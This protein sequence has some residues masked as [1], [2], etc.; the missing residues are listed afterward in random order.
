MEVEM[1]IVVGNEKGGVGKSTIACNLAVVM[2]IEGKD[3]CIVDVDKQQSTSTFFSVRDKDLPSVNCV[4]AR[5]DVFDVLS[6]LD[7][8][9]DEIIVD[10]GGHDSQELRTAM[11]AANLLLVPIKAS[12]IDLWSAED[13]DIGMEKLIAQCKQ[14]NRKLIVKTVLSIIPTCVFG[15]E[16]GDAAAVIKELPY[17]GFLVNTQLK[18]RKVYRESFTKGKGV[19]EMPNKK[20]AD[21]FHSLYKE[22]TYDKICA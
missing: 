16:A 21:E 14:F 17:M 12:Q 11:L 19:V 4:Q 3:V 6:D 9:Y 8:R 13:P 2:A 7:N 10:A 15:N 20:A 1:V 18:D 5:G 22:I